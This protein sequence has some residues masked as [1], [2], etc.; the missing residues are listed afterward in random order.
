MKSK[1]L[2]T[3]AAQRCLVTFI[4]SVT[5]VS[6][7]IITS[8]TVM[9][10]TDVFENNFNPDFKLNLTSRINMKLWMSYVYAHLKLSIR[11]CMSENKGFR[12]ILNLW[13]CFLNCSP[14]CRK[15]NIILQNQKCPTN[16][17]IS[18]IHTSELTTGIILVDKERY[19]SATTE[20]LTLNQANITSENCDIIPHI[21]RPH[22][23]VEIV[24]NFRLDVSLRVNITFIE[25]SL[26]QGQEDVELFNEKC[27]MLITA[28]NY[29]N[30]NCHKV[31][32]FF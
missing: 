14:S 12:Y 27:G 10:S 11:T 4:F 29:K 8:Q 30:I 16:E 19:N 7:N 23:K 1:F 9:D 15:I 31:F 20:Q 13:K 3:V 6:S 25:L 24:Y 5:F 21:W 22:T 26:V 32:T 17:Q 28:V 2:K 18:A